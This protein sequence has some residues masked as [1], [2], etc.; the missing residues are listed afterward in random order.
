MRRNNRWTA[1]LIGV[2]PLLVVG[3][4][5]DDSPTSPIEDPNWHALPALNNL[6]AELTVYDGDLI[7][8]GFFSRAG[9]V[10]ANGIARWD[11]DSWS[12]LGEGLRGGL[13]DLGGVLAMTTYDGNLVVG[14]LFSQAGDVLASNIAQWD[15]TTWS[16]LGSGIQVTSL[17]DGPFCMAVHNGSLY[18][19]GSF[20]DAGGVAVRHIARWDGVSWHAVGDGVSG[21]PV[22]ALG[23]MVVHGGDLF[24]GGS[25]T[26]ID[27]VAAR[28]IARWDGTS[29]SSL[30]S[31]LGEHPD[32]TMVVAQA[33]LGDDLFA[34]GVFRT[35]GGQAASNVA[36]WDGGSWTPLATGT[37]DRVE[38]LCS[39]GGDLIAGGTF[40]RAGQGTARR[41]ARWDGATWSPLGSGVG[42]GLSGLTVVSALA[43]FDESLIVAGN[44]TIAGGKSVG[45]IARWED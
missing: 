6:V 31:G 1:L 39:Y 45:Y 33:V 16:A 2:A 20:L 18:V 7:A 14:G 5:G 37:D 25:F 29:W 35:A 23:S 10:T 3:C 4:G 28:Y 43:V 12:P 24:V 27:D 13:A 17:Q 36:R 34:G 44:F 9:N 26:M 42:G 22:P 30:G 38:V 41:I 21:T 11:G 32:S 40:A 8:G 19:G 15:G